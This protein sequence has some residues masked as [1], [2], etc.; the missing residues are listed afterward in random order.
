M[1]PVSAITG[2]SGHL[3]KNQCVLFYKLSL[4][5]EKLAWIIPR[6]VCESLVKI[7]S[8]F[9]DITASKETAIGGQ[10]IVLATP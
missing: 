3:F 10:N 7:D 9:S 6:R 8:A 1:R 4:S 2:P 5:S